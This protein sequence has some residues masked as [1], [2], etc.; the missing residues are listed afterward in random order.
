LTREVPN[1]VL[2]LSST[3]SAFLTVKL[4]K[5][6]SQRV[7]RR[8]ETDSDFTSVERYVAHVLDQVRGKLESEAARGNR[9]EVSQAEPFSKEDLES[10]E[11]GLKDLGY[12]WNSIERNEN[13]FV[14]LGHL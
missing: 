7:E 13:A 8:F 5:S 10:V 11:Q 12:L 6:L 9:S 4:R 1:L 2:P 14:L 3:L